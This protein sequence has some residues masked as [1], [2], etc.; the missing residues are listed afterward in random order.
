MV[1]KLWAEKYHCSTCGFFDYYLNIRTIFVNIL[2]NETSG[3][4]FL[5]AGNSI[6]VILTVI[7]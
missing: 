6:K 1:K 4:L 2:G 5:L 7:P 3:I